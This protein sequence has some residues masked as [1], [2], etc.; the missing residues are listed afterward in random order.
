MNYLTQLLGSV[1][2]HGLRAD[3]A[4]RELIGR[5]TDEF[6]LLVCQ[7]TGL[8]FDFL[9][10]LKTDVLNN[11][12]SGNVKE[13]GVCKGCTKFGV[14]CKKRTLMDY[15]E[16]HRDQELERDSKKRRIEAHVSS[17]SQSKIHRETIAPGRF[18]F[19]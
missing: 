2:S 19:F 9:V 15:C 6:A 14:P 10:N 1:A 17:Q 5:A 16:Q 3:H 13:P 11:V 7:K 18:K 12:L 8:K 4:A